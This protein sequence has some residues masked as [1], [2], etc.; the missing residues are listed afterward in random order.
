MTDLTAPQRALHAYLLAYRSHGVPQSATA[1][2]TLAES[3]DLGRLVELGL[4][5]MRFVP[6]ARAQ[7]P[8]VGL[9]L[10]AAR[11]CLLGIE[12]AEAEP[13][14]PEGDSEVNDGAPPAPVRTD[15]IVTGL[16]SYAMRPRSPELEPSPPSGA[17]S[18]MDSAAPSEQLVIASAAKQSSPRRVQTS[19][20]TDEVKA[21]FVAAIAAG[22][23]QAEA[24]VAAGFSR[25]AASAYHHKKKDPAFAAAWD[26][27]RKA[28]DAK[29]EAEHPFAP[30][31]ASNDG[32]AELDGA[33][34]EELPGRSDDAGDDPLPQRAGTRTDP[35][36]QAPLGEVAGADREERLGHRGLAP[37][38]KDGTL[39][40]YA[41]RD[42]LKAS[43]LDVFRAV[44]GRW[45]V[46]NLGFVDDTELI[47][48]AER[49][50]AKAAA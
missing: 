9:D 32:D 43:G 40:A 36:G 44:G 25:D 16:G 7:E 5:E 8:P 41:A 22:K 46:P 26:A 30:A 20:W 28:A 37:R 11:K 17:E 12:P 2:M 33:R 10:P 49:V 34:R 38:L 24:H 13:D 3:G 39:D 50:P 1:A 31:P 45:S 6:V 42:V 27:A 19:A 35:G 29:K 23:T 4:V 47:A 14:P 15:V 21:R 18:P 48:L